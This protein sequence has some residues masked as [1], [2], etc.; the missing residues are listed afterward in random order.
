MFI[1]FYYVEE[2][3]LEKG[4][5]NQM[6]HLLNKSRSHSMNLSLYGTGEQND[7]FQLL[8]TLH[9]Q[10]HTHTHMYFSLCILPSCP[11][12]PPYLHVTVG[13]FLVIDKRILILNRCRQ[14]LF[15]FYL[16]WIIP[17]IRFIQ[18][19]QMLGIVEVQIIWKAPDAPPILLKSGQFRI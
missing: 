8:W 7:P 14:P 19:G 12:L 4:Y 9:T 1:L 10:S 6:L 2:H 15:A 13:S 3:V 5:N 17:F 11:F 16:F 18:H